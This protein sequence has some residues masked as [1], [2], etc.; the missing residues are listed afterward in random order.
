MKA[1]SQ[2]AALQK[3][4]HVGCRELGID[5]ETRHD[6]Q[7]LVTGKSSMCDMGQADLEAV[8]AALKARGFEPGFNPDHS[9]PGVKT[10]RPAAERGD[11]RYA[12]VLWRLLAEQGAVKVAGPKGLNAFIRARFA[13]HWGHVPIDVDAM[14][15]WR[16]IKDVVDAL[17]AMCKR[18]GIEVRRLQDRGGAG[19]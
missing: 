12:H 18:A 11:I 6:L 3:L 7:L 10:G 14:R 13:A 4:V 2:K 8:L 9:R 19:R 15:D 16:E 17:K 1:P 5:G